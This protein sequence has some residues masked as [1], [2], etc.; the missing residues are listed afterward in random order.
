MIPPF[1]FALIEAPLNRILQMD[2]AAASRL[3]ALERSSIEIHITSIPAP[4]RLAV[5]GGRLQFELSDSAPD[6]KLSGDLL[7][8]VQ[9]KM[10]A[11]Q[12]RAGQLQIAGDIAAAQRWQQLFADLKPDW[13]EELSR[14]VGDAVARQLALLLQQLQVWSRDSLAQLGKMSAEYVQEEARWV[15][16][17]AELQHFCQDVDS[18]RDDVER[19]LAK[20]GAKGLRP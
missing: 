16:S 19:L 8:F 17:G 9:A 11:G 18:L 15:V 20:A 10:S 13:E 3:Q 2:P 1:L 7:A 14:Y 5:Y 12:L 6:V 4:V